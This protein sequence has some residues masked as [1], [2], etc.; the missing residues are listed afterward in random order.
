MV[1]IGV[2]V[3][4]FCLVLVPWQQS[5]RGDGR[6][7]A[8]APLERQQSIE[9][10][11]PGRIVSWAVQEGEAVAA[12]QLILTIADNDP[13]LMTRLEGQQIGRAHV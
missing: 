9:A 13:E 4:A 8:Y 11:V 1:A 7:I 10:P 3:L 5:V 2:C 12:G 6:L